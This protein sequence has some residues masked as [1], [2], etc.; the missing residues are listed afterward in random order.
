MAAPTGSSG[1]PPASPLLVIREAPLPE[2]SEYSDF[3]RHMRLGKKW[4]DQADS[5]WTGE[6]AE[7]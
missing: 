6:C 3:I 1:I 4:F 7:Q 5:K 2:T